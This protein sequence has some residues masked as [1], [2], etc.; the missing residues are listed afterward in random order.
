MV[1]RVHHFAFLFQICFSC[2]YHYSSI[3]T[4]E[5]VC[6]VA[7]SKIP[8]WILVEMAFNLQMNMGD[9]EIFMVFNH[10]FICSGHIL[11]LL[12]EF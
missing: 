9:I 6:L 10:I 4:P 2:M 5:L 7:T 11:C 1:G 3:C 8:A 12:V